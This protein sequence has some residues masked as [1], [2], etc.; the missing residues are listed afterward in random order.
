[1]RRLLPLLCL[2]FVLSTASAQEALLL[3]VNDGVAGQMDYSKLIDRY[4][5]LADYLS[6]LLKKPVKLESS[7]NLKSST[8]NLMKGRYDLFFSKPSNVAAQ[9]MARANYD[10]VAAVKGA[11][12]VKFIARKDSGL[13]KPEDI[14][15]RRIAYAQ[16][17]FMEKAGMATLRDLGI[18]PKPSELVKARYQ[19]AIAFIVENRFA[20]VGMVSPI[21]AKQWEAKGGITVFESKKLP[22]WSLIASPRLS[23]AQ[24]ATV[25]EGL[26]NAANDP[27]GQKMLN[28]LEIT[29]FEAGDKQ[30]YLDLLAWLARQ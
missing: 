27:L 29:G 20:D 3:G 5:P 17:T 12:T 4:Q 26:L 8:E 7:Q 30:A 23:A 9:A 25:R 15:G 18:V 19:D 13:A 2:L 11:F 14:R 28:S 24:K 16:G 21:V 6:K 10:L 1:M 22:F